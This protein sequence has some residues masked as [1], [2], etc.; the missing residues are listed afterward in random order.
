MPKESSK[1]KTNT[2]IEITRE[3]MARYFYCPQTLAARLLGVSISTL[4]RRFYDLHMGRWPYQC[5]SLNE[6]KKSIY[7]LMNET[8][9]E[10]EKE[11]D[12]K[13]WTY[14]RHAFRD[15]SKPLSSTSS[16]NHS[17]HLASHANNHQNS[18]QFHLCSFVESEDGKVMPT[19]TMVSCTAP[20]TPTMSSG[21]GGVDGW[22][23][24]GGSSSGGS[25]DGMEVVSKQQQQRTRKA[26]QPTHL[27]GSISSPQQP[28]L[29][30]HI[31]FHG[32]KK[33]KKQ[34]QHHNGVPQHGTHRDVVVHHHHTLVNTLPCQAHSRA[35]AAAAL[36]MTVE[37]D[38][39]PPYSGQHS[40][41]QT[42]TAMGVRSCAV[43]GGGHHHE[44]EVVVV[45]SPPVANQQQHHHHYY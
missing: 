42:M 15:A 43:S 34:P 12:E 30:K 14:L 32:E 1:K 26:Q 18:P 24:G 45:A 23:G 35:A 38:N 41:V 2:R 28:L 19:T 25:A 3:M 6:R 31:V 39:H 37:G 16:M 9:P 4:K 22:S 20:T 40:C 17:S 29:M 5:I 36:N 27:G 21:S 33:K 44:E 13:T 8:E 10:D 7:F 11:L